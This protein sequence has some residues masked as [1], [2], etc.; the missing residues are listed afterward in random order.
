MTKAETANK[1]SFIYAQSKYH[2]KFTP[3]HLAFNANLQE[4]AQKLSYIS[5]LHT[6]G[7]LSSERAYEQLASLWQKV[8]QSKRAMNIGSK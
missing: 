2:G 8:E 1:N 7:K 5:A 4:F 6:G 3:E